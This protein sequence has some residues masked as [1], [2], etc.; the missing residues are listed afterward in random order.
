MQALPVTLLVWGQPAGAAS[1]SRH[2][3]T[4]LPSDLAVKL[5]SRKCNNL[6]VQGEMFPPSCFHVHATLCWYYHD[7][8]AEQT[9][10]PQARR[11]SQATTSLVLAEN[12]CLQDTPSLKLPSRQM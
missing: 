9:E 3:K 8:P 2:S 12:C 10:L 5:C 11:A 4:V 1:A 6:R 7:G